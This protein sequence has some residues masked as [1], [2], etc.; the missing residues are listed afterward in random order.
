MRKQ[1]G[2]VVGRVGWE[3]VR[4]LAAGLA[5]AT[6]P[7][8]RRATLTCQGS[9]PLLTA[10]QSLKVLSWNVQYFA[11]KG[12]VFFYDL[13]AHDGPDERPSCGAVTATLEGVAAIIG[14]EQP[15]LILLQEVDDGARRT[16]YE[17]QCARLRALLPSDYVCWVE[18]FYWRV[19]YVPHPRLRGA[20]GNKLV[21]LSR[22]HLRQPVRHPL[23]PIPDDPLTRQF[24]LKRAILEVRLPVASGGELVA[25]NTHLDAFAQGTDTM[26]RQV[27]QC[28][29]LL[30]ARRAEGLPWLIGGDFNLLPSTAAYEALA[31]EQQLYYQPQSEL[32]PLLARYRA[33]P[34]LDEMSGPERAHWYTHFP[35]DPRVPAPDRT[36]DYLFYA[37]ELTLGDHRVRHAETLHL[38]DHLPV[39]ATFRLP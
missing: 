4:L 2:G 14:A 36:L 23:A 16:D 24:N 35:N 31:V 7:R 8:L 21:T 22:Y 27:A 11:G 26:T 3:A 9:A 39:I 20:V 33:V 18:A 12:Y 5:W 17:D 1:R 38:S 15:D 29:N 28:Q 10:G 37:D 34:S 25:M 32:A 19:P 13:P 30:D 6:A